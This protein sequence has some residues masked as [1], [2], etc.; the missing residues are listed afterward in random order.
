MDPIS[1]L[2]GVVAVLALFTALQIDTNIKSPEPGNPK[3]PTV[4]QSRKIPLAVGRTLVSG[5]NVLEATKYITYNNKEE[6][7]N[8]YQNIEFAIAYGPGLIYSIW[9]ADL[10]VW[11]NE[12]DPLSDNGETIYIAK[13]DLWGDK[14][15]GG[16][17]MR[18]DVVFCRGDSLGYIFPGWEALTGRDQPGYPTLSR[19]LF[20]FGPG[21]TRGFSFGNSENY[22]PVEFEYGFFPNPLNHATNHT[23]GTGTNEAANP[24]YVLYEIL[25]GT[26]YGTSSPA[27]IDTDAISAMAATLYTEGVGIRRTWYTESALEIEKELLDLID[28][29]RYRDP[30]TGEVVYKLLR[31]DYSGIPTV[32]DS[33]IINLSIA[34]NSMSGVPNKVS[35]TYLDGDTHYKEKKITE[36]NIASRTSTGYP[37]HKDLDFLG[38]GNS[39]TASRILTRE[40]RKSSKPRRSGRVTLNRIAWDWSRGDTFIINS[41]LEGIVSL[42]VRINEHKRNDLTNRQIT[43]DFIEEVFVAGGAIFDIPTTKIDDNEG[44]AAVITDFTAIPVPRHLYRSGIDGFD[45]AKFGVLATDPATSNSMYIEISNGTWV[46]GAAQNFARPFTPTT[47]FAYNTSTISVIG[48]VESDGDIGNVAID[49]FKNVLIVV[50]SE[51]EYEFICYES[52]SL[53]LVSGETTFSVCSRGL[54]GPQ[55]LSILPTDSVY[56][57]QDLALIDNPLLSGY[58]N[59]NYRL[60]AETGLGEETTATQVISSDDRSAAPQAPGYFGINS[61]DPYPAAQTDGFILQFRSRNYEYAEANGMIPWT[62]GVAETLPASEAMS[63]EVWDKTNDVLILDYPRAYTSEADQTFRL[64]GVTTELEIRGRTEDI[65]SDLISPDVSICTFDYSSFVASTWWVEDSGKHIQY[66]ESGLSATG[67]FIS[68]NFGHLAAINAYPVV[69]GKYYFEVLVNTTSGTW[70]PAI[71]VVD[72]SAK[73]FNNYSDSLLAVQTQDGVAWSGSGTIGSFTTGDRVCV[74]VDT[75]T[76]KVWIRKNNE[77]WAG[78]GDPTT[79]TTPY[80]T[81]TGSGAIVPYADLQDGAAVTAAFESSHAQTAPSEFLP[82]GEIPPAVGDMV[83]VEQADTFHAINLEAITGDLVITEALDILSS[84]STATTADPYFFHTQLLLPMDGVDAS[85]TFADFSSTART[86][87]AAGNAQIDTG[88]S[89]FGGSSGYFDGTGDAV[90][91]PYIAADFDWWTEE[92]TIEMWVRPADLTTIEASS[93][94]CVL[95]HGD[96]GSGGSVYWTF[97]PIADGTVRLWYYTGSVFTVTSTETVSQDEWSHI[98]MCCDGADITIYVNGIGTTPVAVSGSPQ[99]SEAKPLVFGSSNADYDGWI[100]DVRIT[101]GTMRYGTDF[102]P[103]ILA[104]PTGPAFEPTNVGT[105]ELWL[106]AADKSELTLTGTTVDAWGD[107]SG[108]SNDATGVIK[109]LYNAGGRNGLDIIDFAADNMTIAKTSWGNSITLFSASDKTNAT[110][111]NGALFDAATSASF[112]SSVGVRFDRKDGDHNFGVSTG[113]GTLLSDAGSFS[114]WE[115]MRGAYDGTTMEAFVDGGSVGSSTAESGNID[116]ASITET[117]V[118]QHVTGVNRLT[119]SI[120]DLIVYSSSLSTTDAEKVEGYLSHKWGIPLVSGHTYES[121]PPGHVFQPTSLFNGGEAGGFYDYNDLPSMW[122]DTAGT[123]AADT[124]LDDVRRVDDLSGN[125]NNATYSGTTA[126]KLGGSAGNWH[127]D[128]QNIDDTL[129]I[130]TPP[131]TAYW[132]QILDIGADSTGVTILTGNTTYAGTY[133]DGSSS[134]IL[135]QSSGNL[136]HSI[137]GTT[138]TTRDEMHTE[139]TTG[140]QPKMLSIAGVTLGANTKFAGGYTNTGSGRLTGVKLYG[141]VVRDTAFTE[142]ELTEIR[143]YF[144]AT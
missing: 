61:G 82:W 30:L 130:G 96:I 76:R 50:R 75:S 144:N 5:P 73:N 142:Q 121:Y 124:A 25:K 56:R 108:N 119:G 127:L 26:D 95:S 13:P 125:G 79:G 8:F 38:A 88:Q 139:L 45:I 2:I 52:S 51:S 42:P 112:G 131:A 54:Y 86:F 19:A 36:T 32:T 134:T 65:N 89:Q 74:A 78:G 64:T 9:S 94:S 39:V 15:P 98:A 90:H 104:H 136:T 122:Q 137:S 102:T 111:S 120:G 22:R 20:K 110:D 107:K 57:L 80:K 140:I 60:V 17:G 133:E 93:Q 141:A 92:Y 66:S 1:I 85:T 128:T 29:I 59:Q 87:T 97:G 114:G 101:K 67:L 48:A 16:G 103:H 21:E 126:L 46:R 116:Y 35:V 71:G 84:I 135:G 6:G 14:E 11:D 23:I 100:D 4:S 44:A 33:E 58:T 117:Y 106:D 53:N 12:G 69:T 31:D 24:A 81:L 49:L 83:V 68:T 27:Q 123:T 91:T 77:A 43:V 118:G 55:P 115:V 28:G 37:I 113:T 63:I 47:S 41:E 105:I 10:L 99:S 18:G 3:L 129:V 72:Y 62:L 109:P 138:V 132:L 34:A 40:V 7:I 143:A 70:W